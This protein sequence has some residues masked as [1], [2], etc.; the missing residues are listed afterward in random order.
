MPHIIED[1]GEYAESC[2]KQLYAIW[3][4]NFSFIL[5]SFL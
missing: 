5:Y 4:M 2:C 3:N 1:N